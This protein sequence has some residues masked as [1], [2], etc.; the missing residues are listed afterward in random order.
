MRSKRLPGFEKGLQPGQNPRPALNILIVGGIVV[1]ELIV[2]HDHL[3][4]LASVS[5]TESPR[6]IRCPVSIS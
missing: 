2:R 1:C 6:N 5:G 3:H 4:G